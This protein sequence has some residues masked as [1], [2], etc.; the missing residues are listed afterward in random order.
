MI[1]TVL[2]LYERV[3]AN[4]MHLAL[5]FKFHRPLQPPSP[6]YNFPF[7]SYPLVFCDRLYLRKYQ[8]I[9]LE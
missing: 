9:V 3:F 5:S 7:R 6:N 1:F 2:L 8:N 4:F